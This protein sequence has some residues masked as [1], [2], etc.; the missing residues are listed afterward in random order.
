MLLIPFEDAASLRF[1]PL[2]DTRPVYDLRLGI[3][4]PLAIAQAAFPNASGTAL[5]ARS[6]LAATVREQ[7]D[8]PVN[9]IPE[10]VDALLVNGR[11]L[12]YPGDAL[13]RIS[14]AVGGEATAFV[15]D[16]TLVAAWIPARSSS[17]DLPDLLD[18]EALA[19][20]V[21]G[22]IKQIELSTAHLLTDIASLIHGVGEAVERDFEA[23]R[24]G[25]R[26]VEREDVTLS[27]SAV[28]VDP[29]AIYLAPGVTVKAGAV[30]SAESGPIYLDE[31]VTV[32]EGA[33]LRGP[34]YL[35]PAC[36]ANVNAKLDTLAAGPGCKIGGEVHST[37][38]YGFSNKAHDGFVGHSYVG[39]WCNIGAGTDTSNLR[40]DYGPVALYDLNAG[41]VRPTDQLFLGLILGDHSKCSIGTTFNTGTVVGVGGNLYGPGFHDRFVPSFSWGTPGAYQPY[42][43]DKFLRVAEAVMPRRDRTLTEAQEELLRYLSVQA[44][45]ERPTS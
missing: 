2:V 26:Q 15:Q 5:H 37:L 12:A 11:W 29:D 8:L 4:S 28:L 27:P 6:Y 10:G 30:L 38:F 34:L 16:G 36:H 42:R 40:N 22:S 35:G 13:D 44:N 24:R 18:P 33:I 3:R 20:L 45:T 32:H 23:L 14:D 41:E 17:A 21:G 39:Q 25:Y 9:R 7:H 1:R 43:I 31:G 19:D